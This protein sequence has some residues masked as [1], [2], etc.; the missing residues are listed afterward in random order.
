MNVALWLK[1][2]AQL[3]PHA[4]ALLK[5]ERVVATYEEFYRR[6]KGLAGALQTRYA[7]G[8]GDRVAIFMANATEY[9]EVMNAVWIAGATVAPINAKLHPREAA[10]IIENSG[11]KLIISAGKDLAGISK[12]A[13]VAGLPLIDVNSDAYT[14]LYDADPV[15]EPLRQRHSNIAW[16]FYTSGTTGRP[17][18]VMLTHGNILAM[19]L[20][21]FNSVDDTSHSDC[22][23]YAAPISHGAGCYS[24]AFTLR[25]AR[26]IVPES[27]G[28]DPAEIVTLAPK[29]KQL[30]LFAAPTMVRRLV[31][32][33]KSVGYD[34]EGLKTVVYGGGPMYVADIIEAVDVLG[35]RFVQIYGQGESPMTITALSRELIVDR[36]H[37]RWR[38][39]LG[40]VGVAQT[41]VEVIVADE[42]GNELPHGEIGEILVYGTPVMKGYWE[43]EA[44]TRETIR[45]GWLRTGDIGTMDEDGFVTLHD[46]SKDMIISGGTNIYPREVEEA[47]LTHASVAQV[48]VVGK[49]DPEWG[50]TVVAF[51]VAEKGHTLDDAEL[52]RHCLDQIARFK[53]PKQYVH[54]PDLPK[55]AYGKVLKTE[56]RHMLA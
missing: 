40:S 29:L 3:Y 37:P 12:E 8:E 53:R 43:N 50:E 49:P 9:L 45:D 46:R 31:D 26:H 39:R 2:A 35:P 5:G 7:I 28:F 14:G 54:L 56:L 10:W 18:G 19:T 17:K 25:G 21:Y 1:R 33:A 16:L 48:S 42:E 20:T 32:H 34:G 41:S 15:A 52:D 36:T 44:A 47:L 38:E 24:F 6:A 4:P 23:L 11:A 30:C 22:T 55:N 13:T 51:V 27:G